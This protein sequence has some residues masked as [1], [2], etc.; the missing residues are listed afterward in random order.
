[1]SNWIKTGFRLPRTHGMNVVHA[2]VNTAVEVS[3]LISPDMID[4]ET[5]I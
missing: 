4:L 1:M 2:L 5:Q 3:L